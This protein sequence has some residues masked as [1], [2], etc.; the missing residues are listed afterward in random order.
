MLMQLVLGPHFQ[1]TQEEK[2]GKNKQNLDYIGTDP[3]S[4]KT[5]RNSFRS[6]RVVRDGDR[7]GFLTKLGLS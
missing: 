6:W 5:I 2:E 7:N 1:T 4:Q 3:E